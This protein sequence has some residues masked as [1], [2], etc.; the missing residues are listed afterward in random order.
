[1]RILI[2]EDDPIALSVLTRLAAR[3]LDCEVVGHAVPSEALADCFRTTT[4]LVFVDYQLPGMDGIMFIRRLRERAEYVHVPVVMITAE[5]SNALKIEAIEAGATD[6]LRKPFDPE[7][8]KCRSRNL[9]QLRQA[10]LEL[11]DRARLLASEVARATRRLAES[12]EEIIWRLAR[13][14][15]Y[16]DGGTGEHITRVASISRIIAEELGL[17]PDH[18]R[19]IYLGAPLHDV[20]KVGIPDSILNKPG[21]LSDDEFATMRRHVEYGGEILAEGRSNLVRIAARIA[22]AHHEKWDGSGYPRGLAG[23]AIPLEGRIV[24]IADVF[25]ALCS[26]RAYKLAWNPGTARSEIVG[27]SGTHFD[28]ACVAAF[29]RGW[30]R[31]VA[32]LSLQAA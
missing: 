21:K 27:L 4:D 8:L 24:A 30:P 20:G 23:D 11:S 28:P 6:F 14:I 16:R 25:D 22:A 31:L 7:E 3:A 1:M 17:Q 10:Q 2:V 18:C 29:E 32:A 9:L 5:S 15:E 13:A 19:N 26:R 12:E